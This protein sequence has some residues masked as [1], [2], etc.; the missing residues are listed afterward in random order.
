[1]KMDDAHLELGDWI[2][3]FI[4]EKV[5]AAV[6][7]TSYRPPIVG[8]ADASDPLFTTLC[9]VCT[10][11]HR[12]PGDLL[13]GARSVV[14]FFI[15]FTEDLVRCNARHP[16]V[17]REWA[18]AYIE[19]NEVIDAICSELCDQLRQK[20]IGANWASPTYE[21]DTTNLVASWSHKHVAYI[22]GLGTFGVHQMLI[23]EAGCAGR[24]GSIVI[25]APLPISTRSPNQACRHYRGESCLVCVRRCPTEALRPDGFDRHRCYARCLEVDRYYQDLPLCDVCGK[26]ATGPCAIG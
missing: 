24:L 5:A 1:M 23:T 20:G 22:A 19:T 21:F 26:C 15:P 4:V 11:R 17:A 8:F 16:Y 13:A 14:A 12:L 2:R 3:S 18:E 25:G 9:T 10:P 7:R 6:G